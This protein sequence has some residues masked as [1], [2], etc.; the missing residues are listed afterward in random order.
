MQ[1][2]PCDC[3]Q[4]LQKYL[5]QHQAAGEDCNFVQIASWGHTCYNM[6]AKHARGTCADQNTCRASAKLGCDQTVYICLA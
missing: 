5:K 6:T 2:T 1:M 4:G 3:R